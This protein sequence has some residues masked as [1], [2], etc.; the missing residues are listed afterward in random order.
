MRLMELAAW[1]GLGLGLVCSTSSA[2]AGPPADHR[3]MAALPS[4][5]QITA[6]VTAICGAIL[7][8]ANTGFVI[9]HK[10]QKPPKPRRRRR[11]PKP[12]A[13]TPPDAA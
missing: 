4:P 3:H 8:A 1:I 7:T 10:L 2:M 12:D 5:E 6:Y 11:K 13:P 9:W